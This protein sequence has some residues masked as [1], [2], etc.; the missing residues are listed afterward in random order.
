MA[1][2]ALPPMEAQLSTLQVT[3]DATETPL[4]DIISLPVSEISDM[5]RA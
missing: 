4:V 2:A 5:L 3:H 1:T